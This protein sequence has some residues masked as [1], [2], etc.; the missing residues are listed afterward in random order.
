MHTV[1]SHEETPDES[2]R[3]MVLTLMDR[4]AGAQNRD[5]RVRCRA[6][7]LSGGAGGCSDGKVDW[8][9]A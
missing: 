2:Y 8:T 6:D 4:Q 5:R 3:K 9:A 7:A 1:R